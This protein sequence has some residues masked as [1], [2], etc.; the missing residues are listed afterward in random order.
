MASKTKVINEVEFIILHSKKFTD[1]TGKKVIIDSN[2]VIF[3]DLYYIK[4]IKIRPQTRALLIK[5]I[6]NEKSLQVSK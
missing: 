5:Y 3:S 6:E 4:Y 2:K 1:E